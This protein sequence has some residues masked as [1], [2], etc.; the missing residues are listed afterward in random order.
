MDCPDVMTAFTCLQAAYCAH[1]ICNL[2]VNSVLELA[3]RC[4]AA[5]CAVT[6]TLRSR[7]LLL[8]ADY[9]TCTGT[10]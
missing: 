7:K 6:T 2:S 10:G 4:P 3:L 5:Y 8:H 9:L 1:A